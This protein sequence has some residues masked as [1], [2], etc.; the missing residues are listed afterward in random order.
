[1]LVRLQQSDITAFT[2]CLKPLPFLLFLFAESISVCVCVCAGVCVCVCVCVR[3]CVRACLYLYVS[4]SVRVFDCLS[5]CLSARVANQ[6]RSNT[7][8]SRPEERAEQNAH[9][10]S[11]VLGE[12]VQAHTWAMTTKQSQR[13]IAGWTCRSG[14][15]SGLDTTKLLPCNNRSRRVRRVSV[16]F[17]SRTIF[18]GDPPDVRVVCFSTCSTRLPVAAR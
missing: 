16:A 14:S 8:T 11:D 18:S 7:N 1:M 10:K 3:P 13:P 4:V 15:R 9:A 17:Q 2:T 5:F 12:T 6:I